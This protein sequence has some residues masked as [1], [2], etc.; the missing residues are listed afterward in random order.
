MDSPVLPVGD[1][2]PFEDLKR[3]WEKYGPSPFSSQLYRI[4]ERR[5]DSSE[6]LLSWVD[7]NARVTQSISAKDFQAQVQRLS[8]AFERSLGLKKGDRVILCFAPC[9][10]FVI[11]FYACVHTGV[12]AVP[13]YPPDPG[14]AASDIARFCDIAES[15]GA[16]WCLTN[17]F[18]RR[19]VTV[20]TTLIRGEHRERWGSLKWACTPDL[21]NKVSTSERRDAAAMEPSDVCFLQFTSGSTSTPKGVM[22]THGSLLHNIHYILRIMEIDSSVDDPNTSDHAQRYALEDLDSFMEKRHEISRRRRGHRVRGFSWLPLY[23]DMGLIGTLICSIFFDIEMFLMNPLDFIRRPQNWLVGMSQ[24]G[25]AMS[26]APNFA[27][28]LVARKT[29]DA[30]LESLNLSHVCGIVCGA[31]PIRAGTLERFLQRFSVVGMR[32]SMIIPA[33]GLAESTLMVSGRA[34]RRANPAVIAVD[35]GKMRQEGV[36]CKEEQWEISSAQSRPSRSSDSSAS[37]LTLVASGAIFP[38]MEVRIVNAETLSELPEGNVG[39]VWVRS[40]SVAAGYFA[41]PEK[42]RET[43]AG[44]CTLLDGSLSPP[45]FLRTGDSGFVLGGHLYIAGRIKDVIIVRGRNYYPQDLEQAVEETEGIRK[46]CSASFA[47]ECGEAEEERVGIAAEVKEDVQSGGRGWTRWFSRLSGS[48]EDKERGRLDRVAREAASAVLRTSG[49][50][51]HSV[52]LL[53]ARTLPKTSSGKV[54]RSLVRD[55]LMEGRMNSV[56]YQVNIDDSKVLP[57][58][59]AVS[60]TS[61]DESKQVKGGTAGEKGE[62]IVI[63]RTPAAACAGG[64]KSTNSSNNICVSSG[65]SL[66]SQTLQTGPSCASAG[67]SSSSSCSKAAQAVGEG[68]IDS[69]RL[70]GREGVSASVGPGVSVEEG[71]VGS[72]N[73]ENGSGEALKREKVVE[74]VRAAALKVFEM[75][76]QEENREH[77]KGVDFDSPLHEHG[78]DSLQAVEFTEELG[79]SLGLELEPTLL[80]NYP[81]LRDVVAFLSTSAQQHQQDEERGGEGDACVHPQAPSLDPSRLSLGSRVLS[82]EGNRMRPHDVA[83]IGAACRLPGGVRS[84]GEFWNL[85]V[86]GRDAISGVPRSRWDLEEFFDRDPN[87]EGKMYVK[88]GGFL[89]D[90]HLFDNAFFRLSPA[91]AKAM[92]PQQRLLLEVS[93]EAFQSAGREK[94]DLE[95]QNISAYVGCCANDWVDVCRGRAISAFSATSA[96]P[97]ILANRLSYIFG[98]RGLSITVDSACSSSLVAVELAVRELKRG[99][100]GRGRQ[101]AGASG[102]AVTSLA[103]GVNL[104]INPGVTVA[105]CKARMMAP[106]GRCKAFDARADGYVRGEGCCAVVLTRLDS[107]R[108]KGE[109]VLAVVRGSATNHGGR[110]GS[111]TAPRAQGQQEVLQGALRCAGLSPSSVGFLEAHGTGTSLGDPIEMSAVKA[112]FGS[113]RTL[114]RPLLV[115]ALKSNIGHLEGAAGIAGFIKLLL[116]LQ[117]REVPGTLHFESLNPKI[118]IKGFHFAV[119]TETLPFPSSGHAEG[120]LTGGVSSFGFGGTNAHVI[121]QEPASE[122]AAVLP[123]AETEIQRAAQWRHQSFE[124]RAASH[125]LLGQ[126]S[127]DQSSDMQS[128]KDFC[129]LLRSDVRALF[130]DICLSGSPVIPPS[131]LIETMCAAAATGRDDRCVTIRNLS[132]ENPEVNNMVPDCGTSADD[133]SGAVE[134]ADMFLQTSLNLMDEEVTVSSS[135]SRHRSNTCLCATAQLSAGGTSSGPLIQPQIPLSQSAEGESLA[136]VIRR[137]AA[138][139]AESLTDVCRRMGTVRPHGGGLHVRTLKEL[140]IDRSKGEAIASLCYQ[141]RG[142]SRPSEGSSL[143]DCTQSKSPKGDP[144]KIGGM[145]GPRLS[146][147]DLLFRVHPALTEGA[148]QVLQWLLEE[149]SP[150]SRIGVPPRTLIPVS[151]LQVEMGTLGGPRHTREAWAHLQVVK[152]SGPSATC[153][154]RVFDC[155][156][157]LQLHIKELKMKRNLLSRPAT[158]PQQLLWDVRWKTLRAKTTRGAQRNVPEPFSQGSQHRLFLGA[159]KEA[160]EELALLLPRAG[161]KVVAAGSVPEGAEL[162]ELLRSAEWAEVLYLGG[163]TAAPA[164]DVVWEATQILQCATAAVSGKSAEGVESQREVRLSVR[165][166]TSGGVRVSDTDTSSDSLAHHGGLLGLSRAASLEVSSSGKG[167]RVRVGWADVDPLKGVAAG[168]AALVRLTERSDDGRWEAEVAVRGEEVLVPRLAKSGLAVKGPVEVHVTEGAGTGTATKPDGQAE[169]ALSVQTRAQAVSEVQALDLGRDLLEVRVRAVCVSSRD[170]ALLDERT[171]E[172]EG[173]LMSAFAGTVTRVGT[174]VTGVSVGT[175]VFGFASGCLRTVAVAARGLVAEKPRFLTFEETAALLS[176]AA[177]CVEPSLQPLVSGSSVG[178]AETA[179]VSELLDRIAAMTERGEKGIESAVQDALRVRV[180]DVCGRSTDAQAEKDGVAA[181]FRFLESA[182]GERAV[183]SFPSCIEA[184]RAPRIRGGLL[185]AQVSC[186]SREREAVGGCTYIVTGG[187]GGLGLVVAN[188]LLDEG[189]KRLVLVSRRSA[190]DAETAKGGLFMRLI[191]ASAESG[192]RVQVEVR[193]CDVSV[194]E[195][196]ERLLQSVVS[197]ADENGQTVGGR[198]VGRFGIVHSA[199]VLADAQLKDQRE[200]SVRRVFASKVLGGWNIHR[201]LQREGEGLEERLETFVLFSSVASLFGNFGQANYAAA[202]A[203]LDS[204]ATFRQQRGLRAVSIQW[205]PWEEQGMAAGLRD[206]YRLA[207]F[208]GISNDLGLRVLGEAMRASLSPSSSLPASSPAV[209]GCQ[210]VKWGAFLQRYDDVP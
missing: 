188:W 37:S 170:V 198:C 64:T 143:S 80:F 204:L 137:F 51:V 53:K 41:M 199:G 175:D 142:P 168:V 193:A 44:A 10:D 11:S 67:S 31:E 69:W 71:E 132:F 148:L 138:V 98:L 162:V 93:R 20:L 113:T 154:F 103:A 68:S 52:W 191:H 9:L 70:V 195:N 3:L 177:T 144:Q 27:F 85:L 25:T 60:P 128:R 111:L 35:A 163:L 135:S 56:V 165:L 13:V 21:I 139:S 57:A 129:C 2:E 206:K 194:A 192:G 108:A 7:A 99:P 59:P 104:M 156:G 207:G 122:L 153:D 87:A 101:G 114:D 55:L 169:A 120:L 117:R 118:D 130:A 48:A 102:P 8:V 203:A 160:S 66:P 81:T 83:V 82:E 150:P 97:S 152:R 1:P 34:H 178:V 30:V 155:E 75:D 76:V 17:G 84:L 32:P 38:G 174:D 182:D 54:R 205:G 92:D 47:L 184:P 133:L 126:Q 181:A 145:A 96:S 88:V 190:P 171:A 166:L 209:V 210:Q 109:K 42:T 176:S 94:A 14:K 26:A 18:Y 172:S 180:F 46:G 186:S 40:A 147:M 189:A 16:A 15:A 164:T 131:G 146:E 74:A 125:P 116:A 6:N 187:L 197:D 90:S 121:L 65:S 77:D 158:I 45:H 141:P 119:P 201:A 100:D 79:A 29:T 185:S 19:V 106:D 179:G 33:Y 49:V 22:V 161:S 112:V 78:I 173:G 136:N 39:E 202:N 149:T 86:S 5:R 140:R 58:P 124:W 62:R 134:V 159:P 23:H 127:S 208:V 12:V 123:S 63:R 105:F 115:G 43:F 110:A 196:C 72:R 24:H 167:S 200:E 61:E 50:R 107:A 73:G 151:A 157:N 89:E 95:A 4:A 28:E 183:L 91:E 36:V